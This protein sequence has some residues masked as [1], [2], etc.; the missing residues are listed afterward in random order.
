[1]FD[2]EVIMVYICKLKSIQNRSTL[3]Q[4]MMSN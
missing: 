3:K 1:M 4:T 2:K